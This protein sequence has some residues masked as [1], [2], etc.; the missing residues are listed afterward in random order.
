VRHTPHLL[1]DPEWTSERLSLN[2]DQIHHLSRVLRLEPGAPVSYSDGGGHLGEGAFDGDAVLRGAEQTIP[3]PTRPLTVAAVPIRDKARAR[4]LVEKLAEIGVSR[5]VW[6]DSE[7][8][9]AQPPSKAQ[10]WADQAFE[11]SRSAWR[12]KVEAAE[13]TA[14]T[15]SIV[16][17]SPEGGPWPEEPVDVVAVGPEGGWSEA[18]L[19]G[20]WPR[21]SL[22][23]T[24]LRSE[25]AALVAATQCFFRYAPSPHR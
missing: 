4:F 25:T 18:D 15:G 23:Q 17:A 16:A 11:Q 9:Q 19:P 10:Q 22:G 20:D 12:M 5:L 14:L 24:T 7:F 6:I 21:V 3:R 1:V 2:S 13:R 8:G